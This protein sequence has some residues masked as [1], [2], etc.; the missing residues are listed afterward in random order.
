MTNDALARLREIF[1]AA[2]ELPKEERPAYLD[3]ACG[4]DA[5]L[6]ERGHGHGGCDQC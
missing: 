4:N 3:R 2:N 5:E 1:D 6:R